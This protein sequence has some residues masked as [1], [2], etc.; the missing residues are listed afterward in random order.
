MTTRFHLGAFLNSLSPEDKKIAVASICSKMKKTPQTLSHVL[1]HY[2]ESQIRESYAKAI[3][4][5]AGEYLR[6]RMIDPTPFLMPLKYNQKKP[7]YN[8]RKVTI[9]E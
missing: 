8:Q 9:I 1:N 6:R 2:T 4:F 3:D 5:V 7:Y